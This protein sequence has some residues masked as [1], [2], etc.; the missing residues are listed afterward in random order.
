MQ[1]NIQHSGIVDSVSGGH[2]VVRVTRLPACSS[3]R[4]SQRCHSAD[5]GDRL[6]ELPAL[7]D[8]DYHVGDP[9]LVCADASV[10]RFAV[11]LGFCLPLMLLVSMTVLVHV[12]THDDTVAALCGLAVLLPYYLV[13]RI[14]RLKIQR[15]VI[16]RLRK[17]NGTEDNI[18]NKRIQESL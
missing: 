12:M 4:G 15:K 13:L 2:V 16:F 17:I 5:G 18:K 3:C 7:D 1:N 11:L 9:V 6:I 10:G 14:F 8:D